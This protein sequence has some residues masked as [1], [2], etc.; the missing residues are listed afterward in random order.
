VPIFLFRHTWL[1]AWHW[2]VETHAT[3]TQGIMV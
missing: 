1:L 2:Q 3:L